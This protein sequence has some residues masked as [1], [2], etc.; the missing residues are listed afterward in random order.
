[1]RAGR[2]ALDT[3]ADSMHSYFHK[4]CLIQLSA[5]DEHFIIDPLVFEAGDLQPLWEIVGD[6]S[7]PILMHG[8]DYDVRILDRDYGAR[9]A[10][11]LDTQ[12][13]AQLLGEEKTG[14][15]ALLEKEL[16]VALEKKYQRADW[17]RRPLNAPLLEY[18]AADT[19]Y[20]ESLVERLRL[21]LEELDRW[22]WAVD[23]SRRQEDVRHTPVVADPAAFERIKGA[24]ALRGA[25]RDR[26]F[27]L[28]EW[29]DGM[30][31]SKD[32]PP[33][34]ILGNKVLM[35]MAT[36]PPADMNALADM[37]G[38]GPRAVRRWGR[39]LLRLVGSP[40]RAPE[41]V[42]APRSPSPKA[43]VRQRL[44]DLTAV[45]DAKA[46]A[47]KI[48]PGLLCPRG[49]LNEL[50]VSCTT[51]STAEDLVAGGLSGWRFEELGAE[52]LAA[53]KGA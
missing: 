9:V 50:A 45:R 38:L 35:A 19:A 12:L 41:F 28:F 10:G 6:R 16:G 29:R 36:D 17:G 24:R 22:N 46:E 37:D 44:K 52:F 49:C 43:E 2:F 14:L 26:I 47:L 30:A 4:V 33:F 1:M 18:A 13:M 8:S 27:S 39:E 11:L 31:Q 32:V 42:R 5:D 34:K 15:A 53:L 21:R 3:E 23:E 40:D 20:L 25:D 51:S 7:I 48:Q